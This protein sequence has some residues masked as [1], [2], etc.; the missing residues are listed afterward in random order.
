MTCL[1]DSFENIYTLSN[2]CISECVC[3]KLFP[4]GC[5]PRDMWEYTQIRPSSLSGKI[6]IGISICN[7]Q[8]C[9]CL[10]SEPTPNKL[11]SWIYFHDWTWSTARIKFIPTAM[12]VRS[13]PNNCIIVGFSMGGKDEADIRV[14]G[15]YERNFLQRTLLY[16]LGSYTLVLYCRNLLLLQHVE[17]LGNLGLTG[18]K[19][20][21]GR[22]SN[23]WV[24]ASWQPPPCCAAL[25]FVQE[26]QNL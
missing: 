16:R 17:S 13:W 18:F 3:R 15:A 22:I 11:N 14:Y 12:Y 19:I 5:F 2:R 26:E 4:F 20:W 7:V 9:A 24:V 8:R 6:R 25:L 23:H 10:K 1:I 21:T